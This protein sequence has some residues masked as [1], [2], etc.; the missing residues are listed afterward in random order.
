MQV[1]GKKF[2]TLNLGTKHSVGLVAAPVWLANTFFRN[3]V[4]ILFIF[5]MITA[6][7]IKILLKEIEITT[8]SL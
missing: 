2:G 6:H 3:R 7:V 4:D 1:L 8:Q 5:L